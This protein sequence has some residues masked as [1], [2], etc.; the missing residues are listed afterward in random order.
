MTKLLIIGAGGAIGTVLR[1]GL[2]GFVQKLSSG[3]F[4]FGTF[5]VNALGCLL[6]GFLGQALTGPILIREE[7]RLALLVGVLG[8]FTTFSSYAFETFSLANEGERWLPLANVLGSN[9]IG[10]AAVLIGFRLAEKIYGA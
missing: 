8:G 6:I 10:L 2:A 4:P 5:A 9:L 3:S 7:L 1:Y